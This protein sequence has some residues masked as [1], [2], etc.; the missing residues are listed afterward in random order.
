MP[1]RFERLFLGRPRTRQ[2]H[3]DALDGLRGLAV[4]IVIASH[5]SLL[6]FGLVPGGGLGGIGK[7]GVYLFFVLSAFLLTRLLLERT[8]ARCA[9]ARLWAA[10]ALR[11]V[12][13]IWPLYL[14]VLALAWSV[15][16]AGVR[17]WPYQLDTAALAR[18]LALREG[19]SVLWSIPVEFKFYLWLPLM[20]LVVA[21][22]AA[23]R[24][25]L[26]A[27]AGVLVLALVL[28]TWAWPPAATAV[29]DV[30]L[31]PYVVLF[32][33]GGAAAGVDLRLG[34]G[35]TSRA[36]GAAGLVAAAAFALTLP[37]TWAAVT[38]TPVDPKLGHTWFLFFGATWA[39]LLLAVL[40]G[41]RWLRAPFTWAPMRLLGVVS[42]SAYLWHLPV[43]YAMREWGVHAW[44]LAGWWVF[45]AALLVS[46]ASFLLVERPWR[47]VRLP[48][49]GKIPRIFSWRSRT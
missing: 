17:W 19:Q 15:T 42:F 6:G 3:Y 36:W 14:V 7:S 28:A 11:R 21:W 16:R 43:L 48:A 47:D 38:G 39:T 49:D 32:L 24:W 46:M 5:L 41:P 34:G 33:F 31:G 30:R 20:A 29:N 18:H 12:L 8:P 25:P 4:L 27:Q 26:P 1:T 37:G 2:Q 45:A 10:Y 44:P 13:R 22:M 35:L 9:D 23:R 40:H